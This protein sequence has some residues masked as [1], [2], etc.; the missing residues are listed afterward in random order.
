M[1]WAIGSFIIECNSFATTIADKD[2]FQRNGHILFAEKL[3]AYHNKIESELC[4]FID[5]FEK[6]GMSYI[7]ILA[8]TATPFGKV[9]KD[10]YHLIKST[11]QTK[12]TNN[13]AL[14][15]VYIA[16]HGSSLVD[17]IDDPEGDLVQCIRGIIG[18]KPLIISLDFHANVTEKIMKNVTAVIGYNDFPHTHIY[19]TGWKAAVLAKKISQGVNDIN[20]LFIK[21]PMIAPLENMTTAEESEPLSQIIKRL[22]E[23]EKNDEVFALSFFGVHGWLDIEE[24]GVSIVGIV[25]TSVI[26]EISKEMLSIAKEFWSNKDQ[27]YKLESYTLNIAL[28]KAEEYLE[29][30]II[31]NE[32]SDNVGGGAGGDHTHFLR[33]LISNNVKKTSLLTIVDPIA[34]NKAIN[35]GVGNEVEVYLGGKLDPE[36]DSPLKVKGRVRNIFEGEYTYTGN[37]SHGEKRSMGRTVVLVVNTNIFIE[38][39]E[40]PVYTIDPEH[41]WCV[42]LFPEKTKYVLI[43]SQGSYKASYNKIS[44]NVIFLDTPGQCSSDIENLPYKNTAIKKI[45]P[46]NKRLKFTP[47]L[48]K[49]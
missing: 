20:K 9:S 3:I 49:Y 28:K 11:W 38:V 39:T 24:M 17:G 35:T 36:N 45:Y 32:P 12:I 29:F 34:V 1:S 33:A 44:H 6:I 22:E 5:Y 43:K 40:L 2:Y 26:E 16:L 46:F 18:E 14:E 47:T 41:F 30:P 13:E 4:A 21:I 19:N 10:M 15:G 31:F 48:K 8:A 25:K 42:G 27:Y 37:V 7:P 23:L